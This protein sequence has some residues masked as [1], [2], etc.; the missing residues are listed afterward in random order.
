MRSPALIAD[1]CTGAEGD[2]SPEVNLSRSSALVI[3]LRRV[4]SSPETLGDGRRCLGAILT[5]KRHQI[6]ETIDIRT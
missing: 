2:G 4:F 3:S 1:T 5:V 6:T